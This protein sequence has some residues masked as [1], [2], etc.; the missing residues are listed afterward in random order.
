MSG[1]PFVVSGVRVTHREGSVAELEK[2]AYEE[3]QGRVREL[4]G[5]EPVSEAFVFQTCNRVEEY[6]VTETPEAG[7]V[8]LADFSAVDAANVIETGH[9]SSIRHL[10]R[11]AAGLESQVLGEDEIL[12]QLRSAYTEMS[13]SGG[14]GPVLDAALLKAI[15]VGERARTETSINEGI[16]SLGSAAVELA[17]QKYD[18]AEATAVIV[19]AGSMAERIAASLSGTDLPELRIVNRSVE[20]AAALAE[21]VSI[22]SATAGLDELPAHL[23]AA[24]VVISS[25]GS[26]LP[27]IDEGAA[28]GIGETVM[29]DLGQPHDIAADVR[30]LPET[31]VFDLDDLT[32]VTA[33][34]HAKRADA[35]ESVEAIVDDEFDLLMDQYKRNRADT[36]IA[37]M[38]RGAEQ[39]K[40][41]E[42]S[43]ALAQLDEHTELTDEGQEIVEELAD[44][45]VNQLLAVPTKSLRDAA[46]EDDWETIVAAIELFDPE[47]DDPAEFFAAVTRT[48]ETP[49]EGSSE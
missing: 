25:T 20:N 17:T 4:V 49:A 7:Q 44:S 47:V 16:V 29:I 26:Q 8:A 21:E 2:A 41:R 38:Y 18:L 33:S 48:S 36:V 34:T 15:H 3:S 6:V 24:D 11:V 45:L 5:R 46:A 13:E 30:S 31:E 43:R 22:E 28:S 10:L 9:E 19:G 42:V 14:I 32:A 12:G 37:G 40:E 1:Q 27:I 35:A 39:M 23:A